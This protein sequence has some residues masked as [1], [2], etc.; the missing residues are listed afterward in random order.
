MALTWEDGSSNS[1]VRFRGI[2]QLTPF[3]LMLNLASA[4]P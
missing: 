2:E 4:I 3:H 1:N